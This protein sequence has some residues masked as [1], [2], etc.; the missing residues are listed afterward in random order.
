MAGKNKRRKNPWWKSTIA[1]YLIYPL[2]VAFV[3][4]VLTRIW[5]EKPLPPELKVAALQFSSKGLPLSEIIK[6]VEGKTDYD[7]IATKEVKEFKVY[8]TFE[9]NDWIEILRKVV[10]A[11]DE[12]LKLEVDKK[13]KK[14]RMELKRPEK[15]KN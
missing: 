8:G 6:H 1:I 10:N 15:T 5:P 11:H 14:I 13:N 3:I 2:L 12:Q 9:G 7:I 4:F